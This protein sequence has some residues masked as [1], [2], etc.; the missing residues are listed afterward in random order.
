MRNPT[1]RFSDRVDD[2]VKYRPTY[3]SEVID[4]IAQVARLDS[5][6]VVADIGCGTGIFSKLLLQTGAMIVGVEPNE[7][8]LEA[9]K[10]L[11]DSEPRFRAVRATAEATSLE[12]HSYDAVTAAQAFHWFRRDEARAEFQRIL[13]PQGWVFLVWNERLSDT[14]EFAR[15]YEEILKDLATDYAM[16][17]HRNTSDEELLAWFQNSSA[18]I[19]SFDH[20]QSLSLEGLL[21]RAYSSSYVPASGTPER[22]AI[23]NRLTRLFDDCQVDEEI[24]WDYRTKVYLGQLTLSA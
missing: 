3:P 11:L 19:E 5:L 18:R 21:G 10:Q 6:S 22:E 1:E 23:T 16:T 12:D 20:S 24:R 9:A 7:P 4:L 15:G 2:Y 13:K 14:S 8:M 17:R